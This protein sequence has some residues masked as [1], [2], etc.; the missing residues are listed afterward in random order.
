LP[1]SKKI[2][3]YQLVEEIITLTKSETRE[4]KKEIVAIGFSK[5]Q[6]LEFF[7]NPTYLGQIIFNL[8]INTSITYQ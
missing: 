2:Q 7:T 5:N 3:L 6:D 8:I 4:I 1:D